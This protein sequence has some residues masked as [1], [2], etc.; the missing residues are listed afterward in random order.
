MDENRHRSVM[1]AEGVESS[2]LKN[3]VHALLSQ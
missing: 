2:S 1:S 3:R